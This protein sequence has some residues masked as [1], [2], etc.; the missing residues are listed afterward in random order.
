VF[1]LIIE[2][3]YQRAKP[4]AL[5]L[6]SIDEVPKK[7]LR[8]YLLFLCLL[9]LAM[10][11]LLPRLAAMRHALLVVSTLRVPYVL[12]AFGAQILSYLGSGYLLRSVG[13]SKSETLSVFDGVLVTAAANSVGTLGGGVIGTAG[14]TYM[15]LRRK[16][17]DRGRASLGGWLSIYLNNGV[18]A[19]ASLGGLLVLSFLGKS[20]GMLV[21][22]FIF[23]GLTLVA[24][25]AV[26]WAITHRSKIQPAVVAIA[27]FITKLRRKPFDHFK[28]EAAVDNLLEGWDLLAQGGWRKPA[29]G[30]VMNT[31]FD[32][33]TL[34]FFF[35]SAGLHIG[36]ATLLAGYGLPQLLGKLTV[37]LGG[38]GVVD[39]GMVGL[40][41]I[42]GVPKAT[43]VVAVLGYRLF[44]FWLPTLLG[45]PLVPYL[46][47]R[48][49]ATK[50]TM[51]NLK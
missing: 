18:L 4:M 6:G 34:A 28:L 10:Y 2:M 39:A 50:G 51:D 3:Q 35:M 33:L 1:L 47:H 5:D 38:V 36:L 27:G 16:G 40:Y 29:V 23:V 15:F 22:G 37:I 43:A 30:A 45:I 31:G 49:Q 48:E 11:F 26:W 9:G 46:G 21:V 14:M 8:R 7:K 32:I 44:S 25:A 12:L 24:G 19:A 13:K 41:I 20:S 42:L 17:M